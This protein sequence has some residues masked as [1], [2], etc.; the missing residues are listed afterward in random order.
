MFIDDL[1]IPSRPA[2]HLP[3]IWACREKL[4]VFDVLNEHPPRLA[5]A[6]GAECLAVMVLHILSGRVA[7]W[8]MDQ[9]FKHIDLE[10]L[11]GEGWSCT[12]S[13]PTDWA[14]PTAA[15]SQQ[16]TGPAQP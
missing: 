12:G 11:L 10:L 7:L 8:R 16:P 5:H 15:H 3:V 1:Q 14:G 2:G 9:R 6:S 4:G 13:T